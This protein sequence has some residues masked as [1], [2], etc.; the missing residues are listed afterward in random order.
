MILGFAGWRGIGASTAALVC[1]AAMHEFTG[2]TTALV[3][4]DPA[5]GVLAARLGLRPEHAGSLEHLA[6]TATR[7]SADVADLASAAVDHGGVLVVT[8]P[9]DP[10]RAWSC[11]AGRS[12]WIGRLHE[13]ADDVVVDIGRLRGGHPLGALLERL[14][15]LVLV[16]APDAVSLA[17]AVMWAEQAGRTSPGER[18]LPVD[19]VRIAVVDPPGWPAASRT[20]AA[21]ELGDRL[22]GRLPW[23]PVVV[24]HVERRGTLDDRRVRRRPLAL[25]ARRLAGTARTWV[26]GDEG[27]AA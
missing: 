17:T 20:D 12:T 27:N 15:A 16:S 19:V 11:L 6:A 3:E 1:A 18:T 24:D 9:G 22:A 13:L 25:A 14:D 26:R 23:E 2:R 5:G 4:V 10:F 21:T 8:A 7:R